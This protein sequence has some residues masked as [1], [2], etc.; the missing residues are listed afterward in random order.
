MSIPANLEDAYVKITHL[1]NTF[2]LKNEIEFSN[3]KWSYFFTEVVEENDI[4]V[5]PHAFTQTSQGGVSGMLVK[6][7]LGITLS[8]NPLDLKFRQNFSKCH[9]LA[10]FLF[11]V[12][13]YNENMI[14]KDMS[15][16]YDE[17]S[18]E[19]EFEA[20]VAASIILLPDIVLVKLMKTSISFIRMAENLEMSQ[21]AL[22]VRMV[23]FLEFNLSISNISARRVINSFRYDGSKE[24]FNLYISGFGCTLEK[25]IHLNFENAL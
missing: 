1:V 18:S 25:Q 13:S 24:L 11:H 2:I 5:F 19:I 14:F 7:L 4:D 23:Q 6:D 16:S 3:Y 17:S 12:T 8:Y 9:E 15:T 20:N 10:H 22:Y 21:A